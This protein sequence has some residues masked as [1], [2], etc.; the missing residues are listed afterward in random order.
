MQFSH[1]PSP[2]TARFARHQHVRIDAGIVVDIL[3]AVFGDLSPEEPLVEGS[4][5]AFRQRWDAALGRLGFRTAGPGAVTPGCLRGSG[6][7]FLYRARVPISDI[8]WRGRWR[9]MRT[10][11]YYL[12]EVAA[13]ES[14]SD[15]SPAHRD[16]VELLAGHADALVRQ[17]LL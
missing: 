5:Y 2:K 11:E 1:I 15:L 8:A 4:P 6:A 12:Q 3:R 17:T 14:L 9:Q 13:T 16:L 7:T 10:L